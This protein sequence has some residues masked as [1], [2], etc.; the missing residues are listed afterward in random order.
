MPPEPASLA[1]E[2]LE[3]R[4]SLRLIER[5]SARFDGFD[6]ATAY[7]VSAAFRLL[8]EDAGERVVGRKIGFTNRNIWPEYG[9]YGPIWGEVYDTTL[10]D[11]EPGRAVSIAHLS[12]PRLEPEIIL[13][14]DRD[15]S[16]GMSIGDLEQAI[17]WVA[18]GYEIVQTVL[19]DWKFTAADCI[20]EGGLHGLLLVGPRKALKQDERDGLADRLGAIELTLSRDGEQV[21]SGT[22]T[23]VLDGSVHALKHMVDN[24]AGEPSSRS[25]SAGEVVT[26]GT[27]TRAFPI[28]PGQRWSTGLAGYD[29]PGMDVTFS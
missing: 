17:G 24:L 9:V 1:R 5:P 8:R 27:I 20:A 13:G 16:P 3:A 26:T 11:T 6:V 7:G 18:H 22:G 25:V 15:L 29:L 14:I 4:R 21:D 12:Q 19:P 23:N 10:V 28:A 2:I